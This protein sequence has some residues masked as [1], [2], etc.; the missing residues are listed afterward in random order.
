MKVLGVVYGPASIAFLVPFMK[1]RKTEMIAADESVD[2]WAGVT[3]LPCGV[4]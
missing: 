1:M 4:F 2:H 3:V